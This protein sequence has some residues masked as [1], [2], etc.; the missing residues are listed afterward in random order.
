[1]DETR[2][3]ERHIPRRPTFSRAIARIVR[4]LNAVF[5]FLYHSEYNPIYRS[6]TL[7]I[8]LTVVLIITGVY[9]LFFYSVAD[10]YSSVVTIQQQIWLGRWIRALHRYS[11]DA[12]LIAIFFHVLQLLAHGKTW[13]P[14]TL[15]WVSGIMLFFLF[16]ISAWTG[17]VM[18]W[19][20]QGQALALAGARVLQAF[21][22][23]H[24]ELGSAFSGQ[25]KVPSSFFFMNLF[26]HVALPLGLIIGVWIHTARLARTVWFPIPPLFIGSVIGLTLLALL[27]PAILLPEA[28]LLSIVGKIPIDLFLGF[29]IPLLDVATPLSILAGWLIFFIAAASLPWWCRPREAAPT[30]AVDVETCNGCTQ[31][32]RDCPYEAIRMIPHPNGKHLL[33]Q[34]SPELCVSCA[35]CTASCHDLA[36]G[37]PDRDGK[38][39]LTRAK[40]LLDSFPAQTPLGAKIVVIGCWH[41]D[42]VPEFLQGLTLKNPNILFFGLNCCGTLNS[43][44]IELFLQHCR[45]ALLVGCA[46][47]NCMNRD[48]LKLLSGRIFEKRVPFLARDINRKR[49]AICAHSEHEKADIQKALQRLEEN[50]QSDNK[51]L[52]PCPTTRQKS[53]AITKRCVGSAL[54]LGLI[55][56][57]SQTPVGSHSTESRLRI[58]GRLPSYTDLNCRALTD[59]ERASRPL[60]MQQ[61][62]L[63]DREFIQYL[64][65]ISI[66]GTKV[67]ASSLTPDDIAP[68]FFTEDLPVEEGQHA[69]EV[70]LSASS[71][72]FSRHQMQQET[73]VAGRVH[74]VHLD[75]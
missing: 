52:A 75:H 15:A 55:G 48:G 74:L 7:A 26:L 38:A 59:E 57:G 13:G 24:D 34:V 70:E 41:N 53:A 69:Y 9:L 1:M 31:C 73:F 42:S 20:Q 17:Y 3:E 50:L 16:L 56:L 29:W 62:E 67:Y 61:K 43:K 54:F 5:D 66:D 64:V 63:C 14:R 21:P 23:L 27:F 35:I 22:F 49:I 71:P 46:A 47:R 18:V 19:D 68:V 44:T 45:G 11:T 6:G 58:V 72:L 33:A 8:G 10:P 51:N 28:D 60:H 36:I 40:N 12:A 2:L 37:P 65:T 32:V 25:L 39:Q 30:S 4:P